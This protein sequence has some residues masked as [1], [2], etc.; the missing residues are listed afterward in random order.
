[1]QPMTAVP[2]RGVEPVPERAPHGRL[3]HPNHKHRGGECQHKNLLD[4]GHA[5]VHYCG[6]HGQFDRQHG[7][8][9][10]QCQTDL[11]G[12]GQLPAHITNQFRNR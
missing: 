6:M 12:A 4:V 8:H 11:T 1:M 3:G 5:R 7:G 10:G 9:V 2:G